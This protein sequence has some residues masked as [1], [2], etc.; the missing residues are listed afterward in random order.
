MLTRGHVIHAIL[1]CLEPECGWSSEDYKTGQR[2]ASIHARV[3]AHVVSGEV[4]R[5]VEYQPE[6]KDIEC[7]ARRLR[8]AP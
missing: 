5:H 1:R 7:A 2:E 4:G 3:Y 6:P 8:A